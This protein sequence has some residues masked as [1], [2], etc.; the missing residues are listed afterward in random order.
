MEGI[1]SADRHGDG[2]AG[3]RTFIIEAVYS[4]DTG[5]FVVTSQDK[6][7]FWVFDLVCE[8]EADGLEGLFASVYIVAKEEVVCL[9][10]EAAVFKQSE[11]VIILTM[12][13]T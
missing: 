7:V 3:T 9:W 2:I 1:T 13:V 10:G 5:A 4:V 11:E 8:E 6:E 12:D